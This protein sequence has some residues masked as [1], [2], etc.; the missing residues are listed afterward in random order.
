MAISDAAKFFKE[1]V[2]GYVG[3]DPA[4]QNLNKGLLKLVEELHQEVRHLH[5]EIA[6]LSKQVSQIR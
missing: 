4:G 5:Q 2:T 3:S 6:E 1:N